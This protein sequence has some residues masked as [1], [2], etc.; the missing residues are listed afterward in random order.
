MHEP[1]K[2]KIVDT[3]HR[4]EQHI[5]AYPSPLL[6]QLLHS[7][8]KIADNNYDSVLTLVVKSYRFASSAMVICRSTAELIFYTSLILSNVERYLPLYLKSG[9][10][11]QYEAFQRYQN[12]EFFQ[13]NEVEWLRA[14]K[15][16]LE[17]YA[18]IIGITP[19]EKRD[20]TKIPYFPTPTQILSPKKHYIKDLDR[21][22][23]KFLKIFNEEYYCGLLSKLSHYSMSGMALQAAS[24]FPVY[25]KI[26][27]DLVSS[28]PVAIAMMILLVLLSE[29]SL[30]FGFDDRPKLKELWTYLALTIPLHQRLYDAKYR[31]AL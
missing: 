31:E 26:Q 22:T 9:W 16:Y 14:Y 18:T 1:L 2:R 28:Q 29:I 4:L 15:T 20:L 19:D 24:L 23:L 25:P 6:S 8:L 5:D 12:D 7:F 11:E 30:F 13:N 10:R 27:Q 21:K 3:L 17:F